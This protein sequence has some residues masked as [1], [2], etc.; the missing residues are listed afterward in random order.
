MR[1]KSRQFFVDA[2]FFVLLLFCLLILSIGLRYEFSFSSSNAYERT[3][4]AQQRA[5]HAIITET[6]HP[7]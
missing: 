4:E 1:F 7:K 5:T 3:F 2:F 6:A